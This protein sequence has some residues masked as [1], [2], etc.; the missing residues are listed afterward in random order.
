MAAVS[1]LG[2]FMLADFQLQTANL[3]RELSMDGKASGTG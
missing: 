3:D 2:T 1:V